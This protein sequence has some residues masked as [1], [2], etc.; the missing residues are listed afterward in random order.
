MV[1]TYHSEQE[2]TSQYFY[3]DLGNFEVLCKNAIGIIIYVPIQTQKVADF[4]VDYYSKYMIF[5]KNSNLLNNLYSTTLAHAENYMVWTISLKPNC[6]KVNG[7]WK[8]LTNII[9]AQFAC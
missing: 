1:I 5:L 2:K 6:I 3:G 9:H 8:V 4:L 7:S